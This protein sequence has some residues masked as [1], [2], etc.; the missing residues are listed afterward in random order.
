M[1]RAR[2]DADAREGR[3][4][5]RGLHRTT[6]PKGFLHAHP[7]VRPR[8]GADRPRRDRRH[9]HR[10]ERRRSPGRAERHGY[11]RVWY[12]EHHN[13]PGI[14][15]SATSVLIAHVGAHTQT[16]RLGAGGVMLPNHSPLTIAEQ[17]GTLEAMYPGRIDLG[18]GRAPGSDQ[19]TMYAL[20]RDP[21]LGRPLPRR[22]SSSCRATSPARPACPACRRSPARARDVP[23]YVLGS[24][25]FGATLAAALGLPYA[26]ASHFAPQLLEPAVAA[27]RRDFRPSAQLAEPYVIAGVNVIAADTPQRGRGAAAGHPPGARGRA[28]RPRPHAR[29]VDFDDRRRP[30]AGAG[31]GACTSTR[32]SPTPRSARRPRW[33]S[34]WSRFAQAGRRRRADRRLPVA[35]RRGPAALGHPASPRR[36]SPS[37]PDASQAAHSRAREDAPVQLRS[38]G[39]EAI[40]DVLD[41]AVG[42]GHRHDPVVGRT[43]GPAGNAQLTAWTG[44]LLLALVVVELVTLIDVRGLLSWHVVVGML[45]VAVSALKIGSTGWR[46]LRY[47]SGHGT[48]RQA[49]PPPMLLR[50]LGPLVVASTVGVLAS[51]VWLIVVGPDSGRQSLVTLLGQ[52]IDL[53]SIHQGLF[54]VF[55]VVAGVHVLARLVPA[56][57]LTTERAHRNGGSGRL[58]GKGPR[59]AVLALT[60]VAGALAAALI[61][62][63]ASAWHSDVH[64]GFHEFRPGSD[65]R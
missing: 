23:L 19:N 21:A 31:R 11:R 1:F 57:A 4:G 22:T 38:V 30:A 18:L 9:Q 33:A 61:L 58:H 13:M 25:M 5:G 47:Y 14:A 2:A 63:T 35:H 24:S 53:L 44:L 52:R 65:G 16:I 8:P 15:S 48:Y 3:P 37:A 46:F 43:A 26:F 29:G 54:I 56:V 32:C 12:A 64:E 45:L 10:R 40:D 51:G 27:Y 7:A 36:W 39:V 42:R 60:L 28:V 6:D 59:I 49:G 17:F 34:T 41:E 50:I 20:R 55:A 62:P